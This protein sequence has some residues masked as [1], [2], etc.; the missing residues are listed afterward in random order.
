PADRL[1]LRPVD[2][3]ADEARADSASRGHDVV[4]RAEQPVRDAPDDPEP[5]PPRR[6]RAASP[7]A[8]VLTAAS[9]AASTASSAAARHR[10]YRSA[11]GTGP[12]A[13]IARTCGR[14]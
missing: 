4:R 14:N 5:D 9:T 10:A 8:T 2:V 7:S 6:H 11:S 13:R 12:P 3:H 1:D